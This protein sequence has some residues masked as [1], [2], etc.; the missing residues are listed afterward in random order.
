MCGRDAV[1][2]VAECA[3]CWDSN[4]PLTPHKDDCTAGLL[5]YITVVLSNHAE[6][7]GGSAANQNVIVPHFLHFSYFCYRD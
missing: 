3:W 6:D 1:E 4:S 5:I 7:E 2:R